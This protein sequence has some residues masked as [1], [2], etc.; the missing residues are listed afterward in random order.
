M[1][2]WRLYIDKKV[3]DEPDE[4]GLLGGEH[5]RVIDYECEGSPSAEVNKMLESDEQIGNIVVI[6]VGD[7]A[8]RPSEMETDLD[9]HLRRGDWAPDA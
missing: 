1:P 9:L 2:L 4:N 6:T 3:R 7:P 8:A 5:S